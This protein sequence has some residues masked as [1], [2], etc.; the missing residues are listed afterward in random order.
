MRASASVIALG[1][2]SLQGS[3]SAY[4]ARR[5]SAPSQTQ[6][7]TSATLYAVCSARTGTRSDVSHLRQ[8]RV[9]CKARRDGDDGAGGSG[10][11]ELAP[12][13]LALAWDKGPST[14]RRNECAA[15]VEPPNLHP[16]S[17]P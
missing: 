12:P 9:C 15:G 14:S 8:A 5:T 16:G 10:R 2:S 4:S 6:P 13:V 1:G 3:A 11:S 7:H 17:R